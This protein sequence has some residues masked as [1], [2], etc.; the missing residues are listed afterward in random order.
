MLTKVMI[1]DDH[2]LIRI[3][4]KSLIDLQPDMYCVASCASLPELSDAFGCETP[5]VVICDLHFGTINALP[6]IRQT[7]GQVSSKFVV[8]SAY[9][10]DVYAAL[11]WAAG[12]TA[13][14]H[15]SSDSERL[16]ECVRQVA[17]GQALQLVVDPTMNSDDPRSGLGRQIGERLSDREWE[18]F[19]EL[20]N[21][22]STE[23]I[24]SKLF[25]SAKTIESHRINIKRKL[26]ISSKDK[27][28]S[29]ASKI[30]VDQIDRFDG[31]G[32]DS[33]KAC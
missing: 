1:A 30:Q 33:R 14:V 20:G 15:K 9:P 11:C 12:A 25:L 28:V 31:K 22:L 10:S 18:V 32:F 13:F 27:L 24:A 4:L 21:G 29:I 23:E 3:A 7:T 2:Q 5:Q 19:V 17:A 16:L 8:S 26:D 6:F